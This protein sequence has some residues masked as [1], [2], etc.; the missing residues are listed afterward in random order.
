MKAVAAEKS[1]G[2]LFSMF[3]RLLISSEYDKLNE[4]SKT[5][6]RNVFSKQNPNLG[7]EDIIDNMTDKNSDNAVGWLQTESYYNS[8]EY[9]NSYEYQNRYDP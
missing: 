6:F 2:D 1:I 8:E 9:Y 4:L 3:R 7:I 5:N